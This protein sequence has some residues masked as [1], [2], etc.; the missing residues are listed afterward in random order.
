MDL[1]YMLSLGTNRIS[2]LYL[3]IMSYHCGSV[4]VE[5]DN[6]YTLHG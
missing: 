4:V 5:L 3:K 2:D 1:H 6:L